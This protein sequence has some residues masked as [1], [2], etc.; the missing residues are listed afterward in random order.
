[1]ILLLF[2]VVYILS[3]SIFIIFLSFL[4]YFLLRKFPKLKLLY[5]WILCKKTNTKLA[6]LLS[7]DV[8][9]GVSWYVE[10]TLRYYSVY[11]YWLLIERLWSFWSCI[12]SLLQYIV[13]HIRVHCR[14]YW[15]LLSIFIL[16]VFSS[17]WIIVQGF[18][19][20]L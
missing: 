7:N 5:P 8:T 11:Y 6:L 20:Y 4:L 19:T 10:A 13:K 17:I 2:S 3:K 18:H 16:W 9:A 1:M 14:L 12:Q 15:V